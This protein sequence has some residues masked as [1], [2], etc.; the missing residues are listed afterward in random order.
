[1]WCGGSAETCRKQKWG[2]KQVFLTDAPHPTPHPPRVTRHLPLKG[3]AKVS[4]RLQ[5]GQTGKMN[6]QPV[7]LSEVEVSPSGERGETEER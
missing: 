2:D 3:K 7:I 5:D 6:N 4:V 1:M